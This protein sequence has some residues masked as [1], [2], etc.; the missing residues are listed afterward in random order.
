MLIRK[1]MKI[2]ETQDKLLEFQKKQINDTPKTELDVNY[3][4]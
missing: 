2:S 4:L 1:Q 3:R